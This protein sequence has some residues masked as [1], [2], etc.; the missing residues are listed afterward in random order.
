MADMTSASRPE[1]DIRSGSSR[2]PRRGVIEAIHL[3]ALAGGPMESVARVRAIAGIGLEGDRY[4]TASGHYSADAKDDRQV[5]LIGAEE[6]DGLAHGN[7]IVLG[8][9]DT[10]RNITTRGI[11]LNDLVGRRFRIG[12]VECQATRLCEPCQYLADLLA[13]PVLAPLVHRAGL[14]AIIL[15][16]G[17]IALGDEVIA[18]D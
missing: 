5:T 15:S 16:G 6:I 11:Q 4:A 8:P 7:G 1:I 14:R 17:E 2:D 18:I 3:A 10:R 9:G 12:S 13:K